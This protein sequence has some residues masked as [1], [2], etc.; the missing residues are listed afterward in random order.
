ML[1]CAALV[2]CCAAPAV[3]DPVANAPAPASQAEP[4]EAAQSWGDLGRRFVLFVWGK[5]A[6]LSTGDIDA[7]V[8]NPWQLSFATQAKVSTLPPRL[9]MEMYQFVA[10][11]MHAYQF[12]ADPSA[13]MSGALAQGG[14]GSP[15]MTA[16]SAEAGRRLASTFVSTTLSHFRPEDL[17]D[18]TVYALSRQRFFPK[19]DRAWSD[20]KNAL[21]RDDVAVGTMVGLAFA[22]TDSLQARVSGLLLKAPKDLARFG[23]YAEFR[24]LG[25][26]LH[27]T[28]RGGFKAK[29]AAIDVSTGIQQ[30]FGVGPA[31]EL[32]AL[33]FVTNNHWIERIAT[34]QGWELAVTATARYVLAHELPAHDSAVQLLSDAYFRR[35]SF[36]GSSFLSL[37]LRGNVSADFSAGSALSG[38]VGVEDS[39]Y[40][41]AAVVRIAYDSNALLPTQGASVGCLIAGGLESRLDRMRGAMFGGARAVLLRLDNL[42]MIEATLA[43]L[44]GPQVSTTAGSSTFAD[45]ALERDVWRAYLARGRADLALELEQYLSDRD[46]FLRFAGRFNRS[47]QGLEP[48]TPGPLT[49]ALRLAA[50]AELAQPP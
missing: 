36:A 46:A 2:L 28:L 24:D 42:R 8:G 39:R 14:H 38:A 32:R 33:E 47:P 10:G 34:P 50:E 25:F 35:P 23:W 44:Q 16:L 13:A 17:A 6:L 30:N 15:W 22:S 4:A 27:P 31:G 5:P 19:S 1:V 45:L 43:R 11:N 20:W 18:L 40:E 49:A 48:A 21:V 41:I 7:M 26:R 37:L 9:R 29:S 12:V 3:G